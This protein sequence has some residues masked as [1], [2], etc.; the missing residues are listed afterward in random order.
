MS[1]ERESLLRGQDIQS[2]SPDTSERGFFERTHEIA[3]TMRKVSKEK[4]Q[5]AW[6]NS[7]RGLQSSPWFLYNGIKYAFTHGWVWKSL[8]IPFLTFAGLSILLFVVLLVFTWK[9]QVE[10]IDRI[11]YDDDDI[12]AEVYAFY[13]VVQE[14]RFL[15]NILFMAILDSVRRKIYDEI[16]KNEAPEIQYEPL[17]EVSTKERLK[18]TGYSIAITLTLDF[19]TSPLLTVP[20][21]GKILIAL[22]KGWALAWSKLVSS[23]RNH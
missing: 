6:R 8:I 9:L 13:L 15:V 18:I 7:L 3:S 22:A 17:S 23:T 2:D 16:F 14:T 5:E 10:F 11:W 1:E 19:L 21:G 4:S 20:V 12:V